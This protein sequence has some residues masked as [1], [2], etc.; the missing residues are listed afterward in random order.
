MKPIEYI[1]IS[2]VRYALGRM[3]YIVGMTVDFMIK[4]KLGE[5]CRKIMLMDIDDA[6]K[7]H[8]VGMDMDAVEWLR[9]KEHLE[10]TK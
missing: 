4:H 1:Y 3:S 2:A 8:D 6:L 7:R 5:G 10:K 9:L